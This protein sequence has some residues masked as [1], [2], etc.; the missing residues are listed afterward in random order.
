[1]SRAV[2]YLSQH[3]AG[4]P[5]SRDEFAEAQCKEPWRYERVGG[6]LL[7]LPPFDYEDHK[8]ASSVRDQLAAYSFSHP[9]IIEDVF[10]YVWIAVNDDTDRICDIGVY[11]PSNTGPRRIPEF[12]PELIFEIVSTGSESRRRDYVERRSDYERIGVQEYVIVDRFEHQVAVMRLVEGRYAESHLGPTD[13][14]TT[15]LLPALEIP[16][17]GIIGE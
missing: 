4:R 14:Y 11:L 12:I 5:L 3:D 13:V 15:A 16:L 10:Q 6:R 7:V 17:A 2:L 9:T 1:M 8:T